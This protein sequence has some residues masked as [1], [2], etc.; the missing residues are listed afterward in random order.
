MTNPDVFR[1][2]LAMDSYNRGT[3]A[4]AGGFGLNLG[5]DPIGSAVWVKNDEQG[6]NG[7]FATQY[8]WN[9]QT[10]LSFRGTDFANGLPALNDVIAGWVV[11]GGVLGAQLA[12]AYDFYNEVTGGTMAKWAPTTRSIRCRIC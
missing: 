8:T 2:I 5:V 6:L 1:S 3:A 9:S 12:E 4:T 11:G 7:Y 10:V